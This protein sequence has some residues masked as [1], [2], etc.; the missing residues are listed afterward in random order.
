MTDRELLELIAAQVGNLT[1]QVGSLTSQ[2]DNVTSQV[3]NL[4]SQV[5]DLTNQTG[6]LTSQV[7]NLTSQV[8]SLTTKVDKIEEG[9][10]RLERTVAKIEVEH[11][12][13]LQALFD[14]QIQTTHKLEDIE[15]KINELNSK[16][17]R[18]DIQIR[19]IEGGRKR[20]LK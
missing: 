2:V 4:T 8:G 13:K 20:K 16:V 15:T 3:G 10:Q 5:G 17:D 19:V 9:Q 11:G 1:S 14:G 18:H 7:G 6:S 12:N